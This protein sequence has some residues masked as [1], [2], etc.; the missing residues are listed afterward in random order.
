LLLALFFQASES[1]VKPGTTP[2]NLGKVGA[3]EGPAWNPDGWLY[4]SGEGNISRRNADGKVEIFRAAPNGANGLLFDRQK[5]LVACEQSNRRITRTEADGS[6]TVLADQY[7]G[8]HF[9]S[10]NDLTIDSKGR[11]YFSDPRYGKRDGMEIRTSNGR[12]VEGVYRID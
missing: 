1:P 2:T 11:I 12:T 7:E 10:P 3:G 9:N 6:I 4:F 8:K 5:R